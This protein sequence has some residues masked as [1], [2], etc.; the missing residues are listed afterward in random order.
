M[1]WLV[2]L[3]ADV[4]CPQER[5]KTGDVVERRCKALKEH[6][7]LNYFGPQRLGEDWWLAD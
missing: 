7:F 2:P 5:M 6:G 1:V 3:P 4:S